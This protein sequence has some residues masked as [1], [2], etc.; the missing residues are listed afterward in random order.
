MQPVKYTLKKEERLKSRKMITELFHSGKI[1]HSY[2]FK[3]LYILSEEKNK[4]FHAQ[5]A[6]S[7]SKKNFKHAVERNYIKRK[8]RE[9]Y[10]LNKHLL[11]KELIRNNKNVYLFVIYTATE[12]LHI[13]LIEKGIKNLIAKLSKKLS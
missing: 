8:V 13:T 5:F 11:Y 12:D 7:V 1:I 4:E 3:A 6:V 2:P 10:R 9:T